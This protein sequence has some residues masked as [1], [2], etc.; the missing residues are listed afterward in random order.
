MKKLKP[1][2]HKRR[3]TADDVARV[4][5]L[6]KEK[7]HAITDREAKEALAVVADLSPEAHDRIT[8]AVRAARGRR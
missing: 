7:G 5:E 4:V 3:P 8:A 1:Q 6:A 2:A